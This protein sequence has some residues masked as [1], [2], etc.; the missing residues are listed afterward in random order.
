[1]KN[2][3]LHLIGALYGVFVD[4]ICQATIKE[5]E[6]TADKIVRRQIISKSVKTVITAWKTMLSLPQTARDFVKIEDFAINATAKLVS[7][8]GRERCADL[9]VFCFC[10]V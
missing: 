9:E 8:S 5:V 2:S 6:K 4:V 10:S 7:Q 1:L 3:K